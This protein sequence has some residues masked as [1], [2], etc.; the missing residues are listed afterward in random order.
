MFFSDYLNEYLLN[1]CLIESRV[2]QVPI[3]LQFLNQL[4]N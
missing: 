4:K 1:D 3:Y 2:L